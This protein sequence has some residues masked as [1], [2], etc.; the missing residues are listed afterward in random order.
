MGLVNSNAI[1][2]RQEKVKEFITTK[3]VLQE[4]LRG[5][6]QEEEGRR[7]PRRNQPLRCGFCGSSLMW[8]GG[9]RHRPVASILASSSNPR[10]IDRPY[11]P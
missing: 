10:F 3:P 4:R 2:P 8:R 6:L 11:L 9:I 5:L 1:Y 7:K